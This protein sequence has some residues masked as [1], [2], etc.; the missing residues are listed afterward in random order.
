MWL[1][2]PL[3]M[4]NSKGSLGLPHVWK[5]MTSDP[6]LNSFFVLFMDIKQPFWDFTPHLSFWPFLLTP[7]FF[8]FTLCTT[9]TPLWPG[10]PHLIVTFY[11]IRP[12]EQGQPPPSGWV[13]FGRG[14]KHQP[15]GLIS[16]TPHLCLFPVV[17][18]W[19]RILCL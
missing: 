5:L 8:C 6:A 13:P 3:S 18:L 10:K 9:C 15:P 4:E 2:C 17:G 14:I 19:F 11:C 7:Y 12:L 16:H 1:I